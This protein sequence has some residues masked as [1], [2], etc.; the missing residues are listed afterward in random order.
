MPILKAT[1]EPF[2]PSTIPESSTKPNITL[3]EGITPKLSPESNS[4]KQTKNVAK[5]NIKGNVTITNIINRKQTQKQQAYTAAIKHLDKLLSFYT[6]IAAASYYITA[7]F[8]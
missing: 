2:K 7:R 1:S 5:Y 8:H 3:K 4:T 6:I